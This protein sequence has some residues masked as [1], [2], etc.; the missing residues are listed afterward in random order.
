M[1][2]GFGAIGI[3]ALPHFSVRTFLLE[4][5]D[6]RHRMITC[7]L[8]R[9]LQFERTINILFDHLYLSLL[10]LT[11]WCG[12][13]REG[14]AARFLGVEAQRCTAAGHLKMNPLVPASPTKH[15]LDPEA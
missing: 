5:R 15:L 12:F 1:V 10:E 3:Y 11:Y 9:K 13:H 2:R 4:V 6:V 14:P 7:S 8:C